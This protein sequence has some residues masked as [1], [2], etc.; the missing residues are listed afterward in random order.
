MQGTCL[1]LEWSNAMN[2]SRSLLWALVTLFTGATIVD[3]FAPS[4]LLT[5]VQ[6]GLMVGPGTE[7]PQPKAFF[8]QAIAMYA[9]VASHSVLLSKVM[10]HYCDDR[11]AGRSRHPS[12]P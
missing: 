6:L 11:G 8:F 12:E 5:V 2:V 1:A 4:L 10:L 7:S 3:V 9:I